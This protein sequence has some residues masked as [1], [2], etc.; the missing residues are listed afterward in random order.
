VVAE[1]WLVGGDPLCCRRPVWA[2]LADQAVGVFDNDEAPVKRV[3]TVKLI[4]GHA[5]AFAKNEWDADLRVVNRTSRDIVVERVVAIF[6]ARRY[7]QSCRD[8]GKATRVLYPESQL[9]AGSRRD[10]FER[11]HA[12]EG[13]PFKG[14]PNIDRLFGAKRP[15]PLPVAKFR[16]RKNRVTFIVFTDDGAEWRTK[17]KLFYEPRARVSGGGG[18]LPCGLPPFLFC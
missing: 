7:G 10:L 12:G 14:G 11:V 4:E 5:S 13:A 17:V 15:C 8:G 16:R 6:G 2:G 9:R 18:G 1:S 3:G